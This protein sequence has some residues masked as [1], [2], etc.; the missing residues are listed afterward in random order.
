MEKAWIFLV[1]KRACSSQVKPINRWSNSCLTSFCR[2]TKIQLSFGA[3]E[4][5]RFGHKYFFFPKKPQSHFESSGIF[6]TGLHW[7]REIHCHFVNKLEHRQHFF[8][9]F[10]NHFLMVESPPPHPDKFMILTGIKC[11]TT[12][13]WFKKWKKWDK[14]VFGRGLDRWAGWCVVTSHYST[15]IGQEHG[16]EENVTLTTQSSALVGTIILLLLVLGHAGPRGRRGQRR[17]TIHVKHGHTQA[18]IAQGKS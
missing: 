18:T 17:Q 2:P 4:I 12:S 15:P 14:L 10:L 16:G 8:S 1:S 11:P 9:I 13:R 5:F 7:S 3:S 6:S